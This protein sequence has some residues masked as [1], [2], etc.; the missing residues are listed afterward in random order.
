[1]VLPYGED[2]KYKT[3]FYAYWSQTKGRKRV[4]KL[5]GTDWYLVVILVF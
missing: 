5:A 4:K 2:T 3:Y 1:L